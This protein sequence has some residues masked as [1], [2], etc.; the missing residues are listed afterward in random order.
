MY[1][2]ET[3]FFQQLSELL[4]VPS[5][6]IE[7]SVV[8]VLAVIILYLVKII[9]FKEKQDVDQINMASQLV[10]LTSRAF[11]AYDKNTQVISRNTD[12]LSEVKAVLTELSQAVPAYGDSVR[13]Q[14]VPLHKALEDIKKDLI[15]NAS[16]RVVVRNKNGTVFGEFSAVPQTD[17]KGEVYLSVEYELTTKPDETG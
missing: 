4:G 10:T 15:R 17:E 6:A 8:T 7:G 2:A 16:T 5:S 11:D 13:Q 1:I 9:L 12:T 3:T 14:V